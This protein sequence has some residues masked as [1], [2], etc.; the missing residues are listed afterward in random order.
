MWV[1]V[2]ITKISQVSLSNIK[3]HWNDI[4]RVSFRRDFIGL[5]S[6][7]KINV[8]HHAEAIF[9]QRR[10]WSVRLIRRRRRSIICIG[11]SEFLE[12]DFSAGSTLGS[13][14]LSRRPPSVLALFF[15]RLR[16]VHNWFPSPACRSFDKFFKVQRGRS[17]EESTDAISVSA[18]LRPSTR[19]VILAI[20]CRSPSSSYYFFISSAAHTPLLRATFANNER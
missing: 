10:N 9:L 15:F 3:T 6:L 2:L 18:T 13:R 5:A 19:P 1:H 14:P 16:P 8:S 7:S 4:R 17:D 11:A 12:R 20:L